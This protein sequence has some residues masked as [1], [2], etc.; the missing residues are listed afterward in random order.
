MQEL[1]KRAGHDQVDKFVGRSRYA[2]G[3]PQPKFF[4]D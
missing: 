4:Y 1:A 3:I 2:A